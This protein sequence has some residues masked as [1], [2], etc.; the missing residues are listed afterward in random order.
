MPR[1][2]IPFLGIVAV[3]MGYALFTGHAWEDYYITYRPSVNLVE[4]RGLVF[5]PGERLHT[6]TSPLNVLLPALFYWMTGL[7]AGALWLFR[8]VS[9][10]S[11]AGAWT[12]LDRSAERA[13][14]R[15]I[16]RACLFVILAFECKLV[17]FSANGQEIGLMALGLSAFWYALGMEARRFLSLGGALGFLMYTRPDGFVYAGC[18]AAGYLAF[19]EKDRRA[20]IVDL[21]RGGLVAGVAYLPWF[22][23]ATVYYGSVVPHTITAKGSLGLPTGVALSLIDRFQATVQRMV[24]EFGSM[25]QTF[26]PI[27]VTLGGWPEALLA[28]GRT[29]GFAAALYVLWPRASRFGRAASLACFMSHLYLSAVAPYVAPWYLPSTVIPAALSVAFLISDNVLLGRIAA[30]V[31]IGY[32]VSLSAM[33]AIEMKYQQSLIEDQRMRIGLWLKENARTPTDSVFLEPLGYIGFYSGLKMMDY[34]GLA[35]REVVEAR[36]TTRSKR[37]EPIVDLLLPDWIVIRATTRLTAA[38]EKNY[39]VARVFSVHEAVMEYE[40]RYGY[41]TG[42]LQY[43]DT[44][45]VA[46][47]RTAPIGPSGG[48]PSSEVPIAIGSPSPR[49][50]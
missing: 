4:G 26:H 44:F 22:A 21:V 41:G 34:P 16:G 39:E 37:F 25:P 24:S 17:A 48:E 1:R 28:L 3:V 8:L 15:P 43:D 32:V 40:R 13:G 5:Q 11:L 42:Y 35:S 30:P 12:F 27:Y 31:V 6:F 47:R 2:L 23:F 19:V 9:A 45:L 33:N 36:R 50:Y 38:Y 20:A 10:L 14:M 46:R 29:I 18:L 49:D 7:H